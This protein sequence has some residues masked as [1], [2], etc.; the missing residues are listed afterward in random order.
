[1]DEDVIHVYNHPSFPDVFLENRIH[2]S[3][4]GGGGVGETKKHYRR[5]EKTFISDEGGLPLVSIFDSDVIVSPSY[6]Y[7]GEIF[8]SFEFIEEVGDSGKRVGVADRGFVELSVVLAGAEGSVLLFDKEERGGLR[9]KGMADISFLEVV[10]GKRVEFAV[11]SR[12]EAVN[13]SPLG[14]ESGFEIDVMIP[15]SRS[16]EASGGFFVEDGKVLM[17]LAGNLLF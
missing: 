8:C 11:L 5:F 17:V 10:F 3:L 4:E 2:H 9:G 6:V 14:F 7:F 1:M 16:G 12:G 15:G 13:F